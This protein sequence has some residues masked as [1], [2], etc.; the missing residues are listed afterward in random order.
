MNTANA[1][2]HRCYER[3][4]FAVT[5]ESRPFREGSDEVV[6]RMGLATSTVGAPCT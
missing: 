6:E 2:A 3:C 5:G 4:G 1:A